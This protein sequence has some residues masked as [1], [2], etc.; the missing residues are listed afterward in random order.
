MRKLLQFLPVMGLLFCGAVHA[1]TVADL[2]VAGVQ[3]A[4]ASAA[5]RERVMPSAL[6]QALIKISG[7]PGVM[8]LPVIQDASTSVN[9]LIQSY[10]YSTRSDANGQS[11][12][13]LQVTFDKNGLITLLQKAG[14]AIWPSDRPMTLVWL[15]IQDG[16]QTNI[17]SSSN[18]TPLL[19][20]LKKDAETRGI[21]ILLPAMDLQDRSLV[22]SDSTKTFDISKLKQAEKRYA[23]TSIL[24]GKLTGTAD[25]RWHGRWLLLV[26]G[27]P[28]RWENTGSDINSSI[29]GAVADMANLMANQLAVV[30]NKDLRTDVTMEVKDVGDLGDY[31]KVIKILRRLSPVAQVTVKDMTGS[32]L[33]LQIKTLGGEQAL[34]R[35]LASKHLFAALPMSSDQANSKADLYYRWLGD[36]DPNM[37]APEV[38][39]IQS[40]NNLTD[41][42]SA[43]K[44]DVAPSAST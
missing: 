41:D 39:D 36:R 27:V 12:L 2:N 17:L 13:M 43:A 7:N 20:A 44:D 23:A 16:S 31:A 32:E 11:Q 34:T 28:Y 38:T 19:Q 6:G 18:D 35:A 24:A 40:P 30:D 15:N 25:D 5:E 33:I 14:Q 29:A 22:N 1:D 8:T 21:P 3:V 9:D 10:S 42:T 26:N 37:P 4:N